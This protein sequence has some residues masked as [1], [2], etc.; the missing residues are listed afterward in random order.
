MVNL[1]ALAWRSGI[2]AP[3]YKLGFPWPSGRPKKELIPLISISGCGHGGTT[4]LATILGAHP[5]VLLIDK[6]TKWFLGLG[7]LAIGRVNKARD[8]MARS[9]HDSTVK[10]VLEKTPRHVFR[11]PYIRSLFPKTPFV[12][13]VRDPRDLVASIAKRIGDFEGAMVRVRLDLKAVNRVAGD[14]DVLVIR[15]EDLVRDFEKT[16]QKVTKHVG[17]NFDERMAKF[18]DSAPTWFNVGEAKET[19]GAGK[20]AHVSR[21]AWQVQQPLFDG[22]GRYKKDLTPA[23]IE[24]VEVELGPLVRSTYPQVEKHGTV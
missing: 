24:R 11:I 23:Q 9:N 5:N 15:Y 6:E 10:W 16:I 22:S 3:A 12:V 7:P 8:F 18:S 4:L 19:D 1:S 20:A 14:K 21:R 2:W 13:M 17:L